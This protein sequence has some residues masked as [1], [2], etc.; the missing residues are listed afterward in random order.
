ML[1]QATKINVSVLMLTT[2]TFQRECFLF[3]RVSTFLAALFF[4]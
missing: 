3:V 1:Y 4:H 2:I